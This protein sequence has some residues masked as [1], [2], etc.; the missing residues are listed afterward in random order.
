MTKTDPTNEAYGDLQAA[1]EHFNGALFD[2]RLPPCLITFSRKNRTLGYFAAERWQKDS[3]NISDEIALNPQHF[4]TRG[5]RA[6]MSTL[7]HE[8]VHLEQHHFG[9]PGRRGY[10][11]KE[12]GTLME[13]VGLM[14]SNTGQPGGKR[15][16]QQM[17]HYIVDGG[18][19]DR[20]CAVLLKARSVLRY[21]DRWGVDD[22]GVKKLKTKSGKRTKFTCPSCGVSAW[23]KENLRLTCTPCGLEMVSS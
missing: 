23:G 12:W 22:G 21:S 6:V 14:P 19:F 15:V 4:K 7:V 10:H 3:G 9:T 16:G 20:A 5:A 11:N 18:P 8:M 13:R 2:G 1:Y 17:T